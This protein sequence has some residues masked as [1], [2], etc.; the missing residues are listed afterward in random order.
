MF[1]ILL[2]HGPNLNLLGSREPGTYGTVSFDEINTRMKRFAQEHDAELKVFQSNS[3]GALIDAVH[4]AR[5]WAD[6]I[7]INPGAYSHY[8]IALRDA[9]SAVKLPTIEVHLSNIHAR[10]EFRHKL[11]LTPVCIGMICGLGWRSYLYGLEALLAI[12]DEQ[13]K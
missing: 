10:E 12:L 8:S 5:N 1:K 7:V 6:G 4:D 3:E 11:V 2:M 9:F 13:K